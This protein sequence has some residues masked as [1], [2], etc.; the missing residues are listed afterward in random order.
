MVEF[1][2]WEMPLSYNA[3]AGPNVAGGPG[4]WDSYLCS[5]SAPVLR[6]GLPNSRKREND[7]LSS[8]GEIV[9]EQPTA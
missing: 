2:G 8:G 1:A 9:L 4:E 5:R 3:P 6:E 7:V